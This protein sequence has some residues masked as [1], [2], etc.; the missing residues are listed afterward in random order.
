MNFHRLFLTI[1]SCWAI[2][3]GHPANACDVRSNVA[4]VGAGTMPYITAGD[5]TQGQ[6]I[7][8]IHGLFAQKEQW[9]EVLCTLA[10]AGYRPVAPDLPGYGQSHGYDLTAYPLETQVKLLGQFSESIGV[11]PQHVAGNSMGGAI[12]ALYAKTHPESVRSL[13]FIGGPLGIGLWA[14]AV[15]RSILA[16]NNPFIPLTQSALD[17]ELAMLLVHVPSLAPETQ[18]AI[19]SPYQQNTAH[20]IQVWNIVNL[21]GQVLADS[22]R[23]TLPTLIL[24]GDRDQ[25][26]DITDSQALARRYPHHRRQTLHNTGHLAMVDSPNVVSQAYIAFLKRPP[27]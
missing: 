23:S 18:T 22:P 14:D 10:D 8:L 27:R 2:S 15:K 26:F 21:Y 4:Q 17:A 7:L 20:Y 1:L 19:L 25:V 5:A 3:F 11:W 13:A 16:G 6:T 9:A 12:A 24:W